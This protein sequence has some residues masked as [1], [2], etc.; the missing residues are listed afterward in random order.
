MLRLVAIGAG[1]HSQ[2][3]H[4]P[5]LS[6]YVSE[7]PGEIELAA[8]C[9][10]QRE[11]AE[12]M[13]ERYGFARSYTD[14]VEMLRAEQ[15]D[16]CV[17]VTPIPVTAEIASQ[18]VQAKVALLMEKPPG[19]TADEARRVADL[20]ERAGVPVMVSMN[21]RYDPAL[22]AALEWWGDRPIAFLRGRIVRVCRREPDFMYGTA[23][24]PLD[25]MRAIAGD[26]RR[27][28]LQVRN[29]GEV[30]W[31]LIHLTFASGAW[32]VLEV[33]PTGGRLAEAYEWFGDEISAVVGAGDTDSGRVTCW[34][35]GDCVLQCDPSQ[36]MP[37]YV[38]NGTY[39]ETTEFVSALREGR[40]PHPSPREVLQTVE[41]CEQILREAQD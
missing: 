11:R 19:A 31:Y 12:T 34:E 21:R 16:G 36:D 17:A 27:H 29:V 13:A 25:A 33:A 40:A 14:L 35:G 30:R 26:V 9:D 10:L 24:H 39:A 23:I 22:T 8:M 4:L 20:V 1:N 41:L 2:R 6:R 3:N 15:P 7:H 38:R 28:D 5:S 18:V 37:A 32:G